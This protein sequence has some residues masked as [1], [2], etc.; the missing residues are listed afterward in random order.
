MLYFLT[1]CSEGEKRI[2]EVCYYD[3]GIEF[4]AS[5]EPIQ[6]YEDFKNV[7]IN[8]ITLPA[9]VFD[10][11]YT[12]FHI[13]SFK[14][15]WEPECRFCVRTGKQTLYL[16]RGFDAFSENYDSVSVNPHTIYLLREY[17]GYYNRIELEDLKWES[18]IKRFGVPQNYHYSQPSF[19]EFGRRR[20]VFL[21]GK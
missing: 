15:S 19:K 16:S 17:S 21:R 7:P 1:S 14:N 5:I 18:G 3:S 12:G 9:L 4:S 11:I 6:F 20:V 10:S 2:I 8:E 13:T